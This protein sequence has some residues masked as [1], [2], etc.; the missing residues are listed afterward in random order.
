MFTCSICE[1]NKDDS[2]KRTT[3]CCDQVLCADCIAENTEA[4]VRYQGSQYICSMCQKAVTNPDDYDNIVPA[5]TKRAMVAALAA[6]VPVV[7]VVTVSDSELRQNAWMFG[8]Y[9]HSPGCGTM[10]TVY[11]GCDV[12]NCTTCGVQVNIAGGEVGIHT[13]TVDGFFRDIKKFTGQTAA[14][15]LAV[16][17]DTYPVLWDARFLTELTNGIKDGSLVAWIDA[18]TD[19]VWGG[20]RDFLRQRIAP[21]TQA[22]PDGSSLFALIASVGADSADGQL[23]STHYHNVEKPGKLNEIAI[24]IARKNVT[25]QITSEAVQAILRPKFKTNQWWLS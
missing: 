10:L 20:F 13:Y 8:A 24:V 7:K 9:T 21:Q 4:I 17:R 14:N 3:P 5:E 6:L 15:Q 1:E 25:G 22:G 12:L 23:L 18:M 19:T 16:L 2:K 11:E